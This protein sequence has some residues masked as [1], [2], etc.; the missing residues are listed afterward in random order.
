MS[1]KVFL[2][3]ETFLAS[4]TSS[5]LFGKVYLDVIN[6]VDWSLKDNLSNS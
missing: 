3:M 1:C 5:S 4:T 6:V 2:G